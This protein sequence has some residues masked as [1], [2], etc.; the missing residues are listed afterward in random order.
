MYPLLIILS[1]LNISLLALNLLAPVLHARQSI[2]LTEDGIPALQIA[3]DVAPA[4]YSSRNGSAS[5]C[6][7]LGPYISERSA[8]LVM[9]RIRNYG[10]AVQMR[11]LRTMET[12]NYL[13]YIP[14]LPSRAEAEQ[15][16]T[17]MG[18]FDV[19]QYT[20]IEDGPYR[21]AISLGFF[22]QL[23]K[24][25]R[26]SEYI[27]YLGYDAHHTEQKAPRIV[28]WL[29]YDEPFGSNTPVLLWS[30]AIDASSKVQLIPRACRSSSQ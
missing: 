18:R 9:A 28:Y 5:S 22:D 11:S 15:V 29:D 30:E 12:L 19:N 26:H 3:E 13:V 27:R 16:I 17:D 1:L 20:L 10:L 14:P 25:K 7:T 21:N 24:A 6:Y 4:A 23:A 2:P 8:Q